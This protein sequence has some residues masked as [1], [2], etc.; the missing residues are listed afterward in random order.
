MSTVQA[1]SSFQR[2]IRIIFMSNSCQVGCWAI[3]PE[4]IEQGLN[5]RKQI[6][7][8]AKDPPPP[9]RIKNLMVRP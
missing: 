5:E 7:Q 2:G 3:T 4:K 6:V 8:L 9:L 1:F